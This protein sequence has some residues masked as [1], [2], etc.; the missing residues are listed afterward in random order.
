MRVGLILLL[1]GLLLGHGSVIHGIGNNL[2]GNDFIDSCET[3]FSRG[4]INTDDSLDLSDAISLLGFIFFG[5]PIPCMATADINDD[6]VID[7]T[8][9]ILLLDYLYERRTDQQPAVV[10]GPGIPIAA[11][12]PGLAECRSAH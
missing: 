1:L 2:N 9:P 11:R 10:V 6:E 4:N 12:R 5:E 7:L 3:P 8:D